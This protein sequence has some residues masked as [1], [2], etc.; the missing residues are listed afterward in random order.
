MK[1]NIA[2]CSLLLA[3]LASLRAEDNPEFPKFRMVEL[4]EKLTVG[5]AVLL[6][7][8]NGDGKKDIVVVDTQRVLW[9]ENPTWKQAHH[10]PGR[11]QGRQ[12][13][14]LTPTT[15]TATARS[16]SLSAL[17]GS[18]PTP[19]TSGTLQWLKRGKTLDE[20]WQIY[21]DRY[22]ADRPPHPLHRYRRHRQAALVSCPLHRPRQQPD[23]ATGWTALRCRVAAYRIPA[24]PDQGPLGARNFRREHAR[25]PQFLAGAT[26]GVPRAK[27]S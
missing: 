19:K 5:Y 17:S 11:H 16:T 1:N 27:T 10:H 25:R 18:R 7:D 13:L 8:V 26:A 21:P 23:R 9:F 4:D 15:S 24:D 6:A 2:A 20:P 14:H 3:L 12:R 22:G